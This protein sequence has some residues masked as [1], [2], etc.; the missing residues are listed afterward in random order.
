MLK[1]RCPF[2]LHTLS[3][4]LRCN[5]KRG[6]NTKFTIT[7]TEQHE[8]ET[9]MYFNEQFSDVVNY[10]ENEQCEVAGIALGE[11]LNE[12]GVTDA[13]ELIEG[14]SGEIL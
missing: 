12:I 4:D 5:T 3:D 9:P 10:L 2:C 8:P 1:P 13:D 14:L 6:C 7:V 11:I